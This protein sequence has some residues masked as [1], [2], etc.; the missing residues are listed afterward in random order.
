MIRIKDR[1]LYLFGRTISFENS[2]ALM[3]FLSEAKQKEN[4]PKEIVI[5]TCELTDEGLEQILLGAAN[6]IKHKSSQGR[7]VTKQY[8]H[9]LVVSNSCF[10]PR[11][12]SS[13]RALGEDILELKLN[14]IRPTQGFSHSLLTELLYDLSK[15]YPFLFKLSITNINLSNESVVEAIQGLIKTKQ[16]L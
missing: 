15:S 3:R 14:N 12:L 11:S 8:L 6:Q 13:L 1:V 10:G 4:K 16:R 5:D 9:S 2:K 7:T